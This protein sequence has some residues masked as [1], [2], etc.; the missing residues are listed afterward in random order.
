MMVLIMSVFLNTIWL[1]GEISN[2][3]YFNMILNSLIKLSRQLQLMMLGSV[4]LR[5]GVTI[6]T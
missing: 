4:H 1:S 2:L 6:A 5:K 3:H